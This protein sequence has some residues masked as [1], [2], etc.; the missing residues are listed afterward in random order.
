MDP[1]TKMNLHFSAMMALC[2]LLGACG[3]TTQE[4]TP[5]KKPKAYLVSYRQ[6][7]PQPTYNRLTWVNSPDVL[8]SKELPQRPGERIM[9][10]FHL[11]LKN[12]PVDEA[13][14]VIAGTSRYTS[15]CS[16]SDCKHKVSLNTLGTTDELAEELAKKSGM[17]VIVDHDNGEIRVS[18]RSLVVTKTTKPGFYKK[19]APSAVKKESTD[20]IE[21]SAEDLPVEGS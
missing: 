19:K 4:W 3:P 10:I 9:P 17:H 2:S 18:G 15:T 21:T 6:T 11:E 8:P 13:A 16:S 14:L 12:T 20:N 1:Q 7:A 5:A